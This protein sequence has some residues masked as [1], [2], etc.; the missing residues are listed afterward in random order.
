MRCAHLLEI[1]GD[2]AA[3]RLGYRTAARHTTSLPTRHYLE[4]CAARL[5]DDRLVP[6]APVEIDLLALRERR[7]T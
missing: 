5:P 2:Y 4:A 3:A 1:A 7:A 6:I